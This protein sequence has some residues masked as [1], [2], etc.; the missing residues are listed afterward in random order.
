MSRLP[1]TLLAPRLPKSIPKNAKWLA[2]EGAGSWFVIKQEEL[3]FLVSRYSPMGQMECSA[4]MK[5]DGPFN[6]DSKYEF[7][8]PSHCARVTLLQDGQVI[9]LAT[10]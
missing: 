2:G 4:S 3:G 10:L 5:S 9:K 6:L 7:T 1:K 8:F